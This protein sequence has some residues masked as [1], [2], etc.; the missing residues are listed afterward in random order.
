MLTSSWDTRR[1]RIDAGRGFTLVELLIVISIIG[2]LVALTMPAV[3]SAREAGR[4]A[5]CSNNLHQM[6][7]GCLLMESKYGYFPG[8]GWGWQFAGESDRGFGASQPGGWHFQILP[9]IDQADLFNLDKGTVTAGATETSSSVRM[10]AG[11]VQA[12]TPVAVFSCPTR[13]N[14][15]AFPF[16]WDQD[17]GGKS[18]VN[19]NSPP[20]IGRS[21]YAANGGSDY[22]AVPGADNSAYDPRHDWSSDGETVNSTS[23]PT[24]GTIG[25]ASQVTTAMIKDGTSNVYLIDERY[26]DP[27]CYDNGHC[28]DNDQGWDQGYDWDTIRGTGINYVYVDPNT[29]RAYGGTRPQSGV[30]TPIPPAQDRAGFST[31][32]SCSWNFGSAHQAGFNMAFCDGVV[33]LMAWDIDPNVHMQ[34]GHRADGQP[35]QLQA[36][37]G[38][39]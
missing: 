37:A 21:D 31:N 1:N 33:R 19:I 27:N 35:T 20:V 22:I 11:A 39:K 36:I 28:C 13:H 15:K 4:R 23:S 18:Y 29:K 25:V 17:H 7:T 12:Q 3:N 34:L 6:A 32:G 16:T 8:G 38:N 10:A 5:T 9:F 2:I 24:T 26:L 14:V 30:G